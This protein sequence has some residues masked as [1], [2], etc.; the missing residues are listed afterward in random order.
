MKKKTKFN[1]SPKEENEE[2][3]FILV[4]KILTNPRDLEINCLDRWTTSRSYK[5][6]VFFVGT[7]KNLFNFTFSGRKC[8]P[9]STVK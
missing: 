6:S 3:T 2:E 7:L 5:G 4:D 1:Y 9:H 8:L